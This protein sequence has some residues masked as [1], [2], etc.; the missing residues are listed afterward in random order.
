MIEV[1]RFDGSKFHVNSELIEFIEA[2][3]DTVI[4]LTSHKKVIVR[5]RVPEIIDRIIE[6]KRR[7]A[8]FPTI[9]DRASER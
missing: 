9:V 8:A 7:I 3:P 5:E 4:T 2:N 1:T 6:Y